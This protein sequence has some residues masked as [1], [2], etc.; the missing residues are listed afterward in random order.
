MRA[1]PAPRPLLVLLAV[2]VLASLCDAYSYEKG[3]SLK[4]IR[5][6]CPGYYCGRTEFNSTH[7]S[8]C[9]RCPRGHKVANNTHSLCQPC[10]DAPESYDWFF[11]AFHAMIVVTLHWSSV[12]YSV[13][14][15]SLT[16]AVVGM[17]AAA[18]L[19]VA[20]AAAATLLIYGP[21]EAGY[22][23]LNICRVRH[24]SDWYPYFHNPSP[25]YEETLYCTQEVVFPLFTM[26]FTFHFLCVALMLVVRPL[27]ASRLL[28][29][30][31]RST[32]YAA[33]HFLPL[34]SLVHA[35]L[36][37][38][39]YFTYPFI[40]FVISLVSTAS[41][42]AFK[43]DQTPRGLLLGTVTDSRNLVV[44]LAHW[45]LHA[46][47]ICAITQLNPDYFSAWLLA[48]VPLPTLFYI[49]TARFTDPSNFSP[50]TTS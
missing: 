2:L 43:L 5:S 1:P 13:F 30:R 39:V 42:L 48:L 35:V 32:V 25:N 18:A 21:T 8:A 41:H 7:N 29:Q 3:P 4:T 14:C 49:A 40:V 46:F 28:P 15:R 10:E 36:G 38:L 11:L 34:L 16:P 31:G 17:H 37:G 26:V 19:E 9:G 6:P 45:T 22:G 23:R 44:M 24:V 50:E 27:L 47:G 12:D 20:A 33:L